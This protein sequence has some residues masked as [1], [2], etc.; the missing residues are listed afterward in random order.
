MLKTTHNLV[1]DRPNRNNVHEV[2]NGF[3]QIIPNHRTLCEIIND[4]IESRKAAYNYWELLESSAEYKYAKLSH[5][6]WT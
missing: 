1:E 6:Y 4:I 2:I 5:A 3:M